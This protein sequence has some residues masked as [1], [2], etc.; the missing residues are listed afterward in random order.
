MQFTKHADAA[1]IIA[2]A[3]AVMMIKHKRAEKPLR[4]VRCGWDICPNP[5]KRARA[6]DIVR[7]EAEQKPSSFIGCTWG[8]VWAMAGADPN[9]SLTN[10]G[11]SLGYSERAI[12]AILWRNDTA[13]CSWAEQAAALRRYR[14]M[15]DDEIMADVV[16]LGRRI[17]KPF[18]T[19]PV[20]LS[21][22]IGYDEKLTEEAQVVSNLKVAAGAKIELDEL[23]EK[24]ARVP[25]SAS[26]TAATVA[27]IKA[28]ALA[29]RVPAKAQPEEVA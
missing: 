26:S 18:G 7:K 16:E 8:L 1:E 15:R 4:G 12:A 19:R 23:A 6:A 29:P 28:E 24:I 25:P 11:R 20:G 22:I 17:G 3:C 14:S 10:V 13:R 2:R 27:K 21:L 5:K 9:I